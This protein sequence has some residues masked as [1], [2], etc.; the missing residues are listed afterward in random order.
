M[1]GPQ[2]MLDETKVRMLAQ[3][4][5]AGLPQTIRSQSH[6][7]CGVF[8][9]DN[10]AGGLKI[11][12][13]VGYSEGA[14]NN[15]TLGLATCAGEAYTSGE[16]YYCRN[17]ATDRK[18]S[19]LPSATHQYKSIACIPIKA[20]HRTLGVLNID[21]VEAEAFDDDDLVHLQLFSSQFAVLLLK[22]ELIRLSSER[23]VA[24]S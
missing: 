3:Q 11:W 24:S 12:E 22:Q 15:M 9:M 16:V 7:R 8:V 2:I 13:S 5:L 21:A 23:E 6:H 4:V 18:W 1:I 17:T 10:Q 14:V 19:R 20:G